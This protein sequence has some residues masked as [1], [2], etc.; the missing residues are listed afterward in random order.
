MKRTGFKSQRKPIKP[1]SAKKV[2]YR[3]SSAGKA[4]MAH[5]VRVKL[6]PCCICKAPPPSEAHHCRS[7]GLT[8]DDLATI[9]L[10]YECHRGANGYHAT[11]RT[12]E[13]TNGP[14]HGYIAQ[15]LKQTGA[16][17]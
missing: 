12:W 16:V 11:K 4:A 6:L 5:M 14:D 7:S 15:T 1:R 17:E 13:E 3:A 9:P 2:A 10:C 8:R